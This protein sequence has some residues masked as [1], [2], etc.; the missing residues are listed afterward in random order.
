[1]TPVLLYHGVGSADDLWTV[2]P[3]RFADDVALLKDSDRTPLTVADYA[4]RISAPGHALVVSFD[5]GEASNLTSAQLLADAGIPCT[6]Y[7]TA[8]YLDTEGM[9]TT[10]QLRELA[11]VPGV[12]IGSHSLHHVRLDEL[13]RATMAVEL[14]D[15]RARLEDVVQAPVRGVAYPHGSYDRRVK[16]E[17]RDAGYTSGAGVKNAVSHERDD[18]LALARMTLTR[19]SRPED[20]RALLR[21]EGRPGEVRPRLRTVGFRAVRRT[22]AALRR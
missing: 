17:V 3:R 6:V 5:D 11:Q 13:S 9:L 20:L 15:S 22:R 19:E 4:A 18:V 1:M 12:E 2:S 21:G 8:S 10:G 16:A 7:V 14:R